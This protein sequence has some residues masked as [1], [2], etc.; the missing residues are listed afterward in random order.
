[1]ASCRR[2][3]LE[4]ATGRRPRVARPV[5]PGLEKPI[6]SASRQDRSM[7]QKTSNSRSTPRRRTVLVRRHSLVIRLAHWLNVLCL[8][9]L[10]MS[11]LQ[12]FNAY[13]RLHWGQYGADA[14]PAFI[15]IGASGSKG[16]PRGLVRVG[17]AS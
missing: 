4:D 7:A 11:G 17:G 16:E 13:P 10:L 8:A 15:E 5:A 6:H 3:E 2:C 14:D 12:I 9:F 1:M